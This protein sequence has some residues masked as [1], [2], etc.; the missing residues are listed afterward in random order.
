MMICDKIKLRAPEPEDLDLLY[1]WENDPETW[2]VSSTLSPFSKYTLRKYIEN[3]NKSV[4]E[5]GQI[6]FMII[7]GDSGKTIG[8]VDIFDFD[9]FNLRAGVGIL[10]AEKDERRKGFARMAL[11]CVLDYCFNHLKLH[12]VYCNI[13]EENKPSV[14]LF[15]KLGFIKIGVKKDWLR[16]KDGFSNELLYQIISPSSRKD[17]QYP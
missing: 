9:P 17:V 11:Q 16:E 15:E 13:T 1:D 4:F 2:L 8:T 12:Q 5:T 3:S 14:S 10:I 6:R 7:I